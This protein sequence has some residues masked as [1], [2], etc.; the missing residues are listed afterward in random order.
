MSCRPRSPGL[1]TIA[2]QTIDSPNFPA[3]LNPRSALVLLALSVCA[4]AEPEWKADVSS[5]VFGTHPRLDPISLD[6]QMSWKGV[7]NS[8]HFHLEFSAPWDRKPGVYIVKAHGDSQGAAAAI[9][10]YHYNSWSELNP[11]TF[12]PRLVRTA[13]TDKNGGDVSEI[14]YFANRVDTETT[15]RSSDTGKSKIVNRSFAHPAVFDIF[16]AMLYI[17]SQPLAKDDRINLVIQS[18][19]QPYLLKIRCLGRE[20]HEGQKTIKLAAGMRKIDR[21]TLELKDYK[22][23]KNDATLWLSDDNDRIPLEMRADIFWGDVRAVLTSRKK[24]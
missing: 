11:S 10:P 9:H 20:T 12:M 18:G 6:Y 2:F 5:P 24:L 17:R 15:V 23:L 3:A 13:E 21:D 4:I 14:R 19:D 7:L 1:H 8:G 16:S 22:K